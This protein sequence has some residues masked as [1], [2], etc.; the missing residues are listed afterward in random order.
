MQPEERQQINADAK[1][2]DN[3]QTG[4]TSGDTI[5]GSM[6]EGVDAS[7]I[8]IGG[9]VAQAELDAE[10]EEREAVLGE[11]HVGELNGEVVGTPAGR[12]LP[13]TP[14]R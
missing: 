7:R 14:S 3:L 2:R 13:G 5:P 8:Q 1:N 9:G 6:R 4:A 12:P 10:M 11:A